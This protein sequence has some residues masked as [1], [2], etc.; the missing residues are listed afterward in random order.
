M[1]R[2]FLITILLSVYS[3]AEALDAN[4]MGTY[5]INLKQPSQ[6]SEYTIFLTQSGKK[7]SAE[8]GRAWYAKPISDKEHGT[9]IDDQLTFVTSKKVHVL[10][11][12]KNRDITHFFSSLPKSKLTALAP[13]C[14][15][16]SVLAFCICTE[17]AHKVYTLISI[18]GTYA[19]AYYDV[20][21]VS[22]KQ[23]P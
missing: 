14:V 19:P 15:N 13:S 18:A 1:T 9:P 17:E 23:L 8:A 7:W 12:S 2:I 16:N 11:K 20:I 3:V 22:D 5:S 10:Q 21:K 6:P 4:D